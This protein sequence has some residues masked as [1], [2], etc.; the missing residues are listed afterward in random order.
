MIHVPLSQIINK[1]K[2]E[3]GLSEAEINSKIEA[4]LSQLSGLI[5][6]EGAAHIVA[7]ELGVKVLE[8]GGKL[9]IKNI[10]TGMR[11]VETVGKVVR[12]FET[13]DFKTENREG[14]VG[15][16][17][18]GDETGTIRI[19]CWGNQA[20]KIKEL[21]ENDIVVIQ[22]GYVRNNNGNKEVHLNDRSRLI[23][24]PP[25]ETV[26]EV[27]TTSTRTRKKI[28]ELTENDTDVELFGTIVQSFDP[29]FFEVCSLC[30]KRLKQTENGFICQEHG[31]V[32]A[33]YSYVFNVVLDDGSDSIRVVCFK[34]QAENLL[35]KT[36]EDIL[37]L[38]EN[39]VLFEP[40]KND[41][42]GQMVKVVG[43]VSMN[44]MFDRMEFIA[45]LVFTNPEHEEE[46]ARLQNQA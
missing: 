12:I 33:K 43:R 11:S 13:R 5:S 38:R 25:N 41:L 3:K 6:K 18:I 17:I 30:N 27:K 24:N 21:N 19:V 23:I 22:S 20:D 45:Q 40:L 4:K 32:D 36:E 26:G 42:L 37:N 9:K 7:N 28:K 10:L 29:R 31:K 39:P 16:F 15:S 2:E 44:T 8:L 46:I 34:N 35:G 14:K 1:I